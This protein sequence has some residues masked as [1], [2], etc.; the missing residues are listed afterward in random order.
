MNRDFRRATTEWVGWW[1]RLLPSLA[2]AK[3]NASSCRTLEGPSAPVPFCSFCRQVKKYVFFLRDIGKKYVFIVDLNQF[4]FYVRFKWDS[5]Y[6]KGHDK[7]K[8][9]LLKPSGK[10]FVLL[11]IHFV[12]FFVS[13]YWDS[14]HLK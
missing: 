9:L 13:F 10:F 4:F 6:F 11:L 2:S 1:S 7:I 3:T 14:F 8:D 12:Y 5:F